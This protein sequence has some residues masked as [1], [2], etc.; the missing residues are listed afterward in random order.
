M[1]HPI[2]LQDIKRLMKSY[3]IPFYLE[4]K[5]WFVNCHKFAYDGHQ[6]RRRHTIFYTL[7]CPIEKLTICKHSFTKLMF[8]LSCDEHV[9]N[10]R[11]VK[12]LV[13]ENFSP[14]NH[15]FDRTKL[16]V[17]A[18]FESLHWLHTLMKL[19]QLHIDDF[20]YISTEQFRLLLEHTSRLYSLTLRKRQLV[21][22]TDDCGKQ[23][24]RILKF[25]SYENILK[26]LN[27][28]QLEQTRYQFLVRNVK[29]QP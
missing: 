29:I 28:Y 4:E 23:K 21:K 8:T 3:L 25:Q 19:Q 16:V 14:P 12:I 2:S 9:T 17:N 13:F 10:Y 22:L 1:F 7:P 24:I 11:N 26:C 15:D 5:K 18:R 20:E 27:R 6:Y